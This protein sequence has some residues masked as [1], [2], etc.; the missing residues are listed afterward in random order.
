MSMVGAKPIDTMPV[1]KALPVMSS[2]RTVRAMVCIW[3]PPIPS[4]DPAHK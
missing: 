2:T 3:N 1:I 4:I